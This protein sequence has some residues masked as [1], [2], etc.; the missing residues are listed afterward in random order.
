MTTQEKSLRYLRYQFA[1]DEVA[2]MSQ[3]MAQAVAERNETQD[4]KKSV[5]KQLDSEIAQKEATINRLAILVRQ[6]WEMRNLSCLVQMD[7]E[8][9]IYRA[10]RE[11]TGEIVEER[12]L[13]AE[14]LQFALDK[15][16]F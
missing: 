7:Y 12:L 15:E 11:D 13:R 6:G 4:N 10:V 5:I 1:T 16:R 3:E 9:G 14:E 2:K 8:N